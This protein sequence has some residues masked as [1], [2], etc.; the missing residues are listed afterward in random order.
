MAYED[1]IKAVSVFLDSGW[2][3]GGDKVNGK[4]R[5]NRSRALIDCYSDDE[6]RGKQQF[7]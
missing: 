2:V 4:I 6:N 1:S 3:T 7:N 5:A